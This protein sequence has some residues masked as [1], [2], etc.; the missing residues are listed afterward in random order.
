MLGIMAKM[1]GF[2]GFLFVSLF[3]LYFGDTLFF[4][5][6]IIAVC[7]SVVYSGANSSSLLSVV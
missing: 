4:D 7:S 3:Q 5:G 1:I 6:G 2:L